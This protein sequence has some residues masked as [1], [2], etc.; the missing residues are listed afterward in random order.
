MVGPKTLGGVNGLG[1][2]VTKKP[3]VIGAGQVSA[4]EGQAGD[5]GA[6]QAGVIGAGQAGFV[7]GQ[8]GV[9]GAGQA[10]V[11]GAVSGQAVVVGA[12]SGQAVV[13][14]AGSGAAGASLADCVTAVIG[15]PSSYPRTNCVPTE[16]ELSSLSELSV[17]SLSDTE[18]NTEPSRSAIVI[19]RDIKIVFYTSVSTCLAC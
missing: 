7:E 18:R 8:A 12:G 9:I 19:D 14:G 6:G 15:I 5:I 13:V 17:E 4:V 10:V 2:V 3:G 1:N 11:V 16:H